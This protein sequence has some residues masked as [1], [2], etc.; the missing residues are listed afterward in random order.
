VFYQLTN[1]I[2]VC[3]WQNRGSCVVENWP[4][5]DKNRTWTGC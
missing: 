5:D 4:R 1:T 2:L 3:T